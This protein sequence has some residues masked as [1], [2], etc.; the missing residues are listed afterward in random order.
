VEFPK[1][2]TTNELAVIMF[3][4]H[5]LFEGLKFFGSKMMAHTQ[6]FKDMAEIAREIREMK[7]ISA[8]IVET[9]KKTAA[10]FA[11]ILN[12]KSDEESSP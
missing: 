3:L 10:I 7:E 4:W 2:L 1:E 11:K 8:Q 12:E 6:M 5:A 9:Q